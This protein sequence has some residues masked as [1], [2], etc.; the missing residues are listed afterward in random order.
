MDPAEC[1]TDGVKR[2]CPEPIEAW[3]VA[4]YLR[5]N[6]DF[7]ASQA[8]LY[9][10]LA[11]PARVHGPVLADHMEAMLTAT[12]LLAAESARQTEDVL[13]AE[14]ATRGIGERVQEAVLALLRAADPAECVVE[15]WPGLLGIDAACLCCEAIR[16]RWRTLPSGAIRALLRERSMVVRDRPRDA[17]LLHAEAALLAERDMLIAVAG[18]TPAMLA[19]VSRDAGCLPQ[20][21]AWGFLGRVLEAVLF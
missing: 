14:R 11:P 1:P 3:Q 10:V 15:T 8:D 5:A 4:A 17:A 13:A 16:P 21:G 12:R 7:L 9:G 19:L 2:P 6:P 20:S 18:T